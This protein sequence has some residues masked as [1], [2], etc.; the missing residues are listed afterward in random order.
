MKV[1]RESPVKI[2]HR[3]RDVLP[4][5]GGYSSDEAY[6]IGTIIECDCGRQ[7]KAVW[8]GRFTQMSKWR[9]VWFRKSSGG[10]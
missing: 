4:K 1:V 6:P 10:G 2:G 5:P 7:Y 9:R 3:C 8:S